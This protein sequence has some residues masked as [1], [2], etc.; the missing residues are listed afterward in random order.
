M[1]RSWPAWPRS[2]TFI[3]GGPRVLALHAV[4]AFSGAAGFRKRLFPLSC[5]RLGAALFGHVVLERKAMTPWFRIAPL[6]LVAL[7]T[8]CVVAPPPRPYYDQPIVVAP[9][10]PRVE[11]AGPPPAFGHIWIGGYWAWTGH[12]H[13]WVPGHW[14]A[15]R[16]GYHW[17]PHR[18][19][20][21]GDR[22]HEQRG[23]WERHHG[24]RR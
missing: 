7:L 4:G 5:G 24:G 11:Y 12:R 13:D 20:R 6:A 14:E 10:A 8:G 23:R 17:A 9:P 18:W 15:H 16:P 22:W 3:P 19:E 21:H 2:R 1:S